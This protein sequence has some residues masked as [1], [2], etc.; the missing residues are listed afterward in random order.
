MKNGLSKYLL[1]VDPYNKHDERVLILKT[2]FPRYIF[3][4]NRI[5][6]PDSMIIN[7]FG[8]DY[9]VVIRRNMDN[10]VAELHPGAFKDVVRWYHYSKEPE[11]EPETGS[12][13]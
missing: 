4:L 12:V 2:Q 9:Y 11:N 3:E 1:L 13:R 5:D 6:D 10:Q 8:Q 7:L